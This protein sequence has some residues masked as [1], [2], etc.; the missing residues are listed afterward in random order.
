[1]IWGKKWGVIGRETADGRGVRKRGVGGWGG[2]IVGR[3]SG[4]EVVGVGGSC[5]RL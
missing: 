4:V 1:M 2:A 5:F 3:R